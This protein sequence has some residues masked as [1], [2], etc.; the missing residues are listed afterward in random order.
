[1]GTEYHLNHSEDNSI[2]NFHSTSNLKYQRMKLSI[3]YTLAA[4][5]NTE[6]KKETCLDK[7]KWKNFENNTG[8]LGYFVNTMRRLIEHKIERPN[9]QCKL[10]SRVRK[11]YFQM[12]VLRRNCTKKYGKHST[13]QDLK[14]SLQAKKE[15]RAIK[16]AQR[17]EKNRNK[18]DANDVDEDYEEEFEDESLNEVFDASALQEM[19][20][21][22]Q[23]LSGKISTESLQKYCQQ[24]DLDEGE[25]LDCDAFKAKK[26][27]ATKYKAEINYR[28][29]FIT[30]GMRAWIKTYVTP[31]GICSKRT[32][33]WDKRLKKIGI[34][35][36]NT[37]RLYPA[38]KKELNMET[39][40]PVDLN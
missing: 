34:R 6:E 39:T 31:V 37:R 4:I 2:H 16:Q 8:K 32:K 12:N 20:L 28:I 3:L 24:D 22:Q 7:K 5:A 40:K 10:I 21:I 29:N 26:N 11:S 19:G 14:R 18:R 23:N 25:N 38:N 1:M 27:K 35:I 15:A 9:T 33:N 30:K 17:T 13:R 36:Q